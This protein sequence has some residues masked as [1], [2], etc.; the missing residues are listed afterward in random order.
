[1]GHEAFYDLKDT[2]H[3]KL[4]DTVFVGA[5]SLPSGGR[6]LPSDRFLRNF[7]II[8]LSELENKTLS[9]IYTTILK[10]GLCDHDTKWQERAHQIVD[11]TIELFQ[12]VK[13]TLLPT[14]SKSHYVF[15]IRQITELIQGI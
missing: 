2:T 14:P 15:N 5:M 7:S 13:Q 1:M 10:D 8:C 12:T 9:L 3:K 11:I 4:I 6:S